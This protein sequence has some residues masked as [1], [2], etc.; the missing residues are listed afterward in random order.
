MT[1][2][3]MTTTSDERYPDPH[4]V[5]GQ[6]PDL[7]DRDVDEEIWSNSSAGVRLTWR[8]VAEDCR[9]LGRQQQ[10]LVRV[11]YDLDR[12]EHGRHEGD[13]CSGPHPRGCNGSS[14]G[15]PLGAIAYLDNDTEHRE[16]LAY[17]AARQGGV[18]P[19]QIGFT[20]DGHPIVIP[21]PGL[22]RFPD[23]YRPRA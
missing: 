11:L 8:E 18:L 21:E 15:N 10:A 23:A 1:D 6:R 22:P 2:T 16:R 12:C 9:V 4:P 20:I 14:R 13:T 19:R 17:I 7:Y 5:H 3:G